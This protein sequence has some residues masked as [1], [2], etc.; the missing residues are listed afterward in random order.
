[1]QALLIG[2]AS[3]CVMAIS[4]WVL[5]LIAVVAKRKEEDARKAGLRRFLR[6][7]PGRSGSARRRDRSR[8]PIVMHD[9]FKAK[10]EATIWPD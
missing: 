6:L 5:P 8:E 7:W 10:L 2:A 1:M 4:P 3:S 9:R